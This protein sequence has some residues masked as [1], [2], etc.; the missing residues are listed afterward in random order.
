MQVETKEH[1]WTEMTFRDVDVIGVDDQGEPVVFPADDVHTGI[2]CLNC[3]TPFDAATQHAECP[4][5]AP[6]DAQ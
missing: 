2:S 6:D 3:A 4:G 5:G 1:R